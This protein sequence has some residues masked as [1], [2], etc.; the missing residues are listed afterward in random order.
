MVG[1]AIAA[2]TLSSLR[3]G[4][5]REP[6]PGL[7]P[8]VTGVALTCL[9]LL[10][11]LRTAFG[12]LAAERR[13][14]ALWHGR[15]WKKVCYI[16]TALVICFVMLRWAGFLLTT[17]CLMIFLLAVIGGKTWKYAL[18]V[19]VVISV[20]SYGLFYYLLQVELPAGFLGF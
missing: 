12:R 4:A 2:Y 6:G 7:F 15:E 17:T 5:F 8:L 20:C 13:L 10:Q 9:A 19:A 3:I 11:L 14:A 18:G 16:T 1:T